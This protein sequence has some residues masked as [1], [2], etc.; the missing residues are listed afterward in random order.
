MYKNQKIGFTLIELLVVVAIIALLVAIILPTMGK[1][2]AAA[3]RAGC[4]ANL[5]SIGQA[6]RSYMS[7]NADFYP[8]M[9]NMPSLEASLHPTNPRLPMC[10]EKLLG[11]YLGNQKKV[12]RCPADKIMD[13]GET[14]PAGVKTWFEWQGSSYEPRTGLSIVTATGY[15]MVSREGGGPDDLNVSNIVLAHD[16]ENFHGPK[17]SPQSTMALFADFHAADMGE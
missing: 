7:E 14:P 5:R 2:R 6:I 12:F 3:R 4:L 11:Q 17:G 13:P 10:D 15:W 16:Y 9:A 1:A 8:P